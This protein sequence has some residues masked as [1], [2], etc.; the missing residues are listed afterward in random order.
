MES[1]HKKRIATGLALALIPAL[2]ILLG[3][4]VLFGALTIF[5]ALTFIE[6]LDMF[7]PMRG[8]YVYKAL[9]CAFTLLLL[10]SFQI[11]TGT[12]WP[13]ITFIGAFWAAAMTF[14][15]HYSADPQST[16]FREPIVF[17]AGLA[18]IPLNLHFFLQFDR[19]ECI[20]VI[21]AAT[22][23][24]TAA[25]Y[26]GSIFGKRKIWP[27][28]SPKKSW[29]G[30]FGGLGA[31]MAMTLVFGL[32]FGNAPFWAWLV[33]GAALNVAAQLGD[34]FESAM[35]RVLGVKDSGSS[36]PGHGGLLDRIDSL[37]FV[38]PVYGCARLLHA[39]FE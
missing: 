32:S 19:F 22:V 34:F 14:L 13:A 11:A 5:G 37:L 3:G 33:L 8:E 1:T 36:L 2:G 6:Y 38:L 4:W 7:R 39:F 25:F 28:V 27:T 15:L 9:A 26:S 29:A 17:L 20:L 35:K 24:D 30:S 31:C 12:Q 18:Y 16:G 10:L 21:L 23:S